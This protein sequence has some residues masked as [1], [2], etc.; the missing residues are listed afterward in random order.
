LGVAKGDVVS[1]MPN[2]GNSWRCIW[3]VRI[4]AVT[5]PLMPIFRQREL[6]FMPA[7]G[8]DTDRAARFRDFDYPAMV[9]KFAPACRTCATC[10]R[11]AARES[12]SSAL[13]DRPWEREMDGPC[14]PGRLPAVIQVLYTSGTTGERA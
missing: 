9:E 10:W 13:I 1:Q 5:N 3:P 2:G 11:S 7:W 14:L 12:R 4:G 6:E 8:Q